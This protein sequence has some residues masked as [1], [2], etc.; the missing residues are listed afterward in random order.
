MHVDSILYCCIF[1][2]SFQGDIRA[3]E[4]WGLTLLQ[5]LFLREHNRIATE[6][7]RLNPSWDDETVYQGARRIN[8]AVY[9][10]IVYKEFLPIV[11]GIILARH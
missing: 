6:L 7:Q 3:N 1:Y 8:I 5:Q 11:L 2:D 4:Q 9:Q 10:N